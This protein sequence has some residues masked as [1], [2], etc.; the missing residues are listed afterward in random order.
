MDKYQTMI[1]WI[2]FASEDAR[3]NAGIK[4]PEEIKDDFMKVAT[5]CFNE[6][7]AGDLVLADGRVITIPEI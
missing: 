6:F 1:E 2:E 7:L 5:A 3:N 4:T